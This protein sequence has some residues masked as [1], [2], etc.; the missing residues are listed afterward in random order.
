MLSEYAIYS[1]QSM[2]LLQILFDCV[3]AYIFI[4]YVHVQIAG[5]GFEQ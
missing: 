4:R 3:D 2:C 1:A 5:A